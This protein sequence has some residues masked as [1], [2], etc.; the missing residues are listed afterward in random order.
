MHDTVPDPLIVLDLVAHPDL[1][2][3]LLPKEENKLRDLNGPG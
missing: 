3:D 1:K 2:T